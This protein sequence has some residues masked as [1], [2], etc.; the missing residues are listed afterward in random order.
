MGPAPFIVRIREDDTHHRV[1]GVT[2]G[3]MGPKFGWNSKDNG[4]LAFDHVRVPR[5]NL[6]N[7]FISVDREGSFSIEGDLRV[8]YATMMGIRSLLVEQSPFVMNMAII[9]GVRYSIVRRQFRN[10]S[11]S[12]EETRLIDYQTQQHKL[13]PVVSKCFIQYISAAFLKDQFKQML[14]EIGEQNFDRLLLVHHLSS[15]FKSL[16]T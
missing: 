4:W 10:T 7:R 13:V 15:G 5:A 14:V 9:I 8:L 2:S 1:K 16:F 12:K 11:G 3:D 6:L